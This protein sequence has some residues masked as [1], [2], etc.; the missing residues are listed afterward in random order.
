MLTCLKECILE[1]VFILMN[2]F[3]NALLS[4][5]TDILALTSI[6]VTHVSPAPRFDRVTKP[7]L[8]SLITG[9]LVLH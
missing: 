4:L 1:G 8:A 3:S 6:D 2:P 5:E 9:N 7:A